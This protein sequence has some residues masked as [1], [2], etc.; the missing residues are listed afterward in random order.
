MNLHSTFAGKE[1]VLIPSGEMSTCTSRAIKKAFE[2]AK[3]EDGKSI[4]EL[5]MAL[6]GVG[7]EVRS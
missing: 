7:R 6:L 1:H 3:D 4:M 5:G 2:T